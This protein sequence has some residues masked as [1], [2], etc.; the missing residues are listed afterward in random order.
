[1]QYKM[2]I[3]RARVNIKSLT[4]EA[5]IIR[6]EIRRASD[7]W[8][9]NDLHNHRMLKVRPEA[10]LA[11]LAMAFLKGHPKSTAEVTEKT[12]DVKRLH[13]KISIFIGYSTKAVSLQEIQDWLKS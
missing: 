4:A 13:S 12:I 5:V 2:A 1:M 6:K 9:K 8:V 7:T 10:R 3:K 11:N